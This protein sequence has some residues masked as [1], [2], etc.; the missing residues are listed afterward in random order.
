MLRTAVLGVPTDAA[1]VPIEAEVDGLGPV[2]HAVVERRHGDDL[3]RRAHGEDAGALRVNRCPALAVYRRNM[4]KLHGHVSPACG[5]VT[6][7]D[8]DLRELSPFPHVL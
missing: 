6:R 7:V 8:G 1:P 4:V 2:E 5:A 3:A